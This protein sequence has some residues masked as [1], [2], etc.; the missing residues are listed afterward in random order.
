[1]PP[2]VTESTPAAEEEMPQASSI[3]A[4]TTIRLDVSEDEAENRAEDK[5][6]ATLA[7][8]R[9]QFSLNS[10]PIRKHSISR[11]VLILY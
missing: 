7:G 1:M 4:I 8:D 3:A 9:A 5:D 6:I 11:P 2:S 10:L